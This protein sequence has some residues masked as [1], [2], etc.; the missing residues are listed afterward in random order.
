M[1]LKSPQDSSEL[2]TCRLVRQSLSFNK[3]KYSLPEFD[4]R[5]NLIVTAV[6]IFESLEEM[7][8]N[9][10]SIVQTILEIDAIC[11]Q[12]ISE[13]EHHFITKL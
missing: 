7:P 6:L 13:E 12:L 5:Y 3:R 8:R 2:L 1:I 10:F 9:H 11:L 4:K